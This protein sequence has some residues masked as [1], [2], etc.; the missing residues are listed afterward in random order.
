MLKHHVKAV[1]ASVDPWFPVNQWNRL[2]KHA[3]ITI[4]SLRPSILNP[5]LSA[6]AYLFSYLNLQSIHLDPPGT[7]VLAHSKPDKHGSWDLSA[8][9]GW[10]MRLELE[11]Y[12]CV[13]IYLPK[14]RAFRDCDTV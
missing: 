14:T 6:H 2:I 4:N 13:D 9:D 3:T 11:H 12:R 7:K 5:K 8:E 1:L 10:Y